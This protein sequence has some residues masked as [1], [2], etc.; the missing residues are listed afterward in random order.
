MASP[1]IENDDGIYFAHVTEI[2]EDGKEVLKEILDSEARSEGKTSKDS[3]DESVSSKSND[4]YDQN[5]SS[6]SISSISDTPFVLIDSSDENLKSVLKESVSV[7]KDSTN[8]TPEKHQKRVTFE[9]DHID[10]HYES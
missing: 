8:S 7:K 1:K 10:K 3:N 4:T 6:E 9:M 5:S 2:T